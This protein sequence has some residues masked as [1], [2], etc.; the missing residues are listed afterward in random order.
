MPNEVPARGTISVLPICWGFRGRAASAAHRNVC[1]SSGRVERAGLLSCCRSILKRRRHDIVTTHE[2][3]RPQPT[4]HLP[5]PARPDRHASGVGV[6]GG[7]RTAA[8]QDDF[9][10]PDPRW[11]LD[12]TAVFAANGQLIVKPDPGAFLSPT[13]DG[14]RF[15]SATF[16]LDVQTPADLNPTDRDGAG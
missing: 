6:P 15:R 7:I 16:C 5:L 1:S 4:A 2:H 3:D 14:P 12:G 10:R 9:K 8:F 11:P 13:V